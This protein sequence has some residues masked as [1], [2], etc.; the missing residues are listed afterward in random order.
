VRSGGERGEICYGFHV[1]KDDCN[2]LS[3]LPALKLCKEACSRA[4]AGSICCT[5]PIQFAVR[6]DE[7][8]RASFLSLRLQKGCTVY[9]MINKL[10]TCAPTLPRRSTNHC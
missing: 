5:Q 2:V 7:L 9:T 4:C 1:C 3:F 10:T 6:G 8:E